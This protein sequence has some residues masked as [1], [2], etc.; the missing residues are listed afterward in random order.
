MAGREGEKME[1]ESVYLLLD[2]K[3]DLYPRLPLVFQ[4]ATWPRGQAL[5]KKL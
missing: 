1:E 4:P 5:V 2:I 3:H